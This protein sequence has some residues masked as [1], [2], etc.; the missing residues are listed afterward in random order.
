MKPILQSATGALQSGSAEVINSH[1]QYEVFNDPK[2]VGYSFVPI[3]YV[4]H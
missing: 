1:D 4:A 2:A 3:C